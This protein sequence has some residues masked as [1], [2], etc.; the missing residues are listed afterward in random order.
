MLNDCWV[1]KLKLPLRRVPLQVPSTYA[2][3]VVTLKH[4]GSDFKVARGGWISVV[5]TK[6]PKGK[7]QKTTKEKFPHRESNPGRMGENHVS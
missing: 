5:S 3:E 4:K 7:E 6:G 2:N 1:P